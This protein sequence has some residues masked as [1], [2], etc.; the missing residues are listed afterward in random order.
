M[1]LLL[2]KVFFFFLDDGTKLDSFCVFR[3]CGFFVFIDA[4]ENALKQKMQLAHK[5]NIIFVY[6]DQAR[7]TNSKVVLCA[8]EFDCVNASPQ[9]QKKHILHLIWPAAP[10][11][12]CG[13]TTH[14]PMSLLLMIISPI[15]LASSSPFRGRY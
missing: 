10:T 15:D 8:S 13:H 14:T 11:S 9:Q 6:F 3:S 7:H 5:K 12:E 1:L 4:I 2:V